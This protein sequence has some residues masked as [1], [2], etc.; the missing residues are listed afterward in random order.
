M[1][2]IQSA[3]KVPTLAPFLI[4]SKPFLIK[5]NGGEFDKSEVLKGNLEPDGSGG[6][7]R[8]P[9]VRPA[10]DLTKKKRE[11]WVWMVEVRRMQRAVVGGPEP[12]D[13]W[14]DF[15]KERRHAPYGFGGKASALRRMM[16]LMEREAHNVASGIAE[17]R[18]VPHYIG[19]VPDDEDWYRVAWPEPKKSTE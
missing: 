2:Q 11:H 12:M 16:Q 15:T 19:Y 18:V 8:K 17:F 3:T 7:R 13:L 9:R 5:S 1:A 14:G 4:N 6:W 10:F